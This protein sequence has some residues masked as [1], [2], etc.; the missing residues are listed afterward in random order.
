MATASVCSNNGVVTDFGLLNKC[1]S[2]AKDDCNGYPDSE[3]A[4]CDNNEAV[5]YSW[6]A[7]DGVDYFVHIRADGVSEFTLVVTGV[8]EEPEEAPSGGPV[9][10]SAG[11]KSIIDFFF[12][13]VL[14][15][16]ICLF[17]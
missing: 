14:S 16:A 5:T 1:N 3:L 9:P 4:L 13:T 15:W 6:R 12:S 2:N 11:S 8:M 7:E 10:N 17:V